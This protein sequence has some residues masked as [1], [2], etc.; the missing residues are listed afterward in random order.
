MSFEGYFQIL[1]QN[2]HLRECDCYVEPMFFRNNKEEEPEYPLWTCSC[3][4]HAA[5]WNLVDETNGSICCSWDEEQ[6]VCCDTDYCNQ[7]Q[8][9]ACRQKCGRID[10]FVDLEVLDEQ[11]TETCESCGHTKVIR[12]VTYRIPE[13]IGHR[14]PSGR[15][16]NLAI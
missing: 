8:Y 14:V 1:C 9:A 7:E 13:G 12:E 5:W 3:G 10:G 6:D 16:G 2:G 11:E 4:A 15:P